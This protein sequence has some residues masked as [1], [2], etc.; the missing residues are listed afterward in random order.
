MPKRI[1]V[2]KEEKSVKKFWPDFVTARDSE[3]FENEPELVE[4]IVFLA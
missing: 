1:Y 4:D 3:D 2:I